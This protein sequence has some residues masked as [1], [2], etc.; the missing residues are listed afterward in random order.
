MRFAHTEV[1]THELVDMKA[2]YLCLYILFKI[3]FTCLSNFSSICLR[4][5]FKL[6]DSN[7]VMNCSF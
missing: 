4:K 6:H 3:C 2:C 5:M 1:T 7:N